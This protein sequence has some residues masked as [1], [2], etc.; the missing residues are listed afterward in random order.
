MPRKLPWVASSSAAV[1]SKRSAGTP[2]TK[3]QKVKNASS[4]SD[5]KGTIASSRKGKPRE[6]SQYHLLTV[7]VCF[8]K[9]GLTTSEDC[10]ASSSP[11]PDPPSESFM[12]DGK[13]N[14][15]KYRM[16]EDEFLTVAQQFTVHLHAAEYKR[17][18]SAFKSQNAEA[19]NSISR[20]VTGKMPDQTKRK[21]EATA[22]AKRQRAIIAGI[23]GKKESGANSDDSDIE[24]LPYIGTTL[25][26]LMDSPRKKAASL[27]RLNSVATT[28]AAAGFKPAIQTNTDLHTS[29]VDSPKPKHA[30]R[31]AQ[32]QLLVESSDDDD[33]DDLDAPIPAPNLLALN[34]TPA[35]SFSL[36]SLSVKT[37]TIKREPLTSTSHVPKMEPHVKTEPSLSSSILG[38]MSS[39]H[40]EDAPKPSRLERIRLARA[41]KEKAQKIK[42]EED[43][44]TIPISD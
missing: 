37:T 14:D 3:R 28:R 8:E 6:P 5:E 7:I 20:P 34:R 40:M 43:Y 25:H 35:T 12:A 27:A 24:E 18:Q 30:L 44:N 26:G 23:L 21:L 33:D 13:D 17:Q 39:H 42:K 19:I 4:D 15:D 2:T 11:P 32:A 9:H 10:P 29:L 36:H 22:V 38:T 41:K 31:Q 16:V 1:P